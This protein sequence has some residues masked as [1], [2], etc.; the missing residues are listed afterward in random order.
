[1]LEQ[2]TLTEL[3]DILTIESPKG[4]ALEI[5]NRESWGLSFCAAGKITYRH[6]G[7]KFVSDKSCA[8]LLP[9][10][11]SYSLSGEESG[12]FPL[13]N[14]ECTG[15]ENR[16]FLTIPLADPESYLEDFERIKDFSLFANRELAVKSIF[17]DILSRLSAENLTRNDLI[18]PGVQYI[19]LHYG[20]AGLT[21]DLLAETCK[22]S[23][24][25]FR[26]LFV[27]KF[28]ISP[29]QYILDIRLKKAKQLL[30]NHAMTVTQIAEQCGF[31][32]V[33]HF[34]RFFKQNTGTT[35]G[36]FRSRV[37]KT[38]L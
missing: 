36:K 31:T 9:K 20:D 27:R 2:L 6:N 5:K 4:R 35:P 29:K 17:Y 8:V 21:N 7:K 28:G 34:C 15:Y 19:H 3:E 13:I 32:S 22:I 37:Q 11:E 25:Y 10:G 26:K 33:Y 16:E 12:L 14:F 1:M 18:D 23:E 38:A 24:I 30:E